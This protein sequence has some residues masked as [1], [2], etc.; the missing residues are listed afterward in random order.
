MYL[1]SLDEFICEIEVNMCILTLLNIAA[2]PS[3]KVIL[4]D[5][6][7]NSMWENQSFHNYACTD[8]YQCLLWNR[9]VEKG[10]H[11]FNLHFFIDEGEHFWHLYRLYVF[12]LWITHSCPL[13]VLIC[14]L[15]F[16]YWFVGTLYLVW[17]LLCMYIYLYTHWLWIVD[18][19]I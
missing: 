8:H 18:L 9:E 14:F 4:I 2:L 5:T 16:T 3:K 19:F 7:T 6:F 17:M 1:C 12:L 11:G 15:S 13:T 10:S